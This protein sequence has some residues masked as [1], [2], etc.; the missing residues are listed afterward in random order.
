[1]ENT[2]YMDSL[3]NNLQVKSGNS[4]GKQR[5]SQTNAAFAA[6]RPA[7]VILHQGLPQK[8]HADKDK[9]GVNA[10]DEQSRAEMA[11]DRTVGQ[12]G[13]NVRRQGQMVR[14]G[15]LLRTQPRL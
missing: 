12:D 5:C 6:A 2:A 15:Y 4:T 9:A 11:D 7:A 8:G 14:T 3:R 1:M 13:S 10:G